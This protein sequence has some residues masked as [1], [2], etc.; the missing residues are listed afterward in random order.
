MQESFHRCDIGIGNILLHEEGEPVESVFT[1]LET[2]LEIFK[3]IGPDAAGTHDRLEVKLAALL[4]KAKIDTRCNG[5]I[6]DGD[7]AINL[8]EYFS[9]THEGSR[10][11]WLLNLVLMHDTD[12]FAGNCRIHVPR[13]VRLYRAGKAISAIPCR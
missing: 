1:N 10:S 3:R 11:V 9:I 12:I 13:H 7:A 8:K 2:A 4:K 6:I 5:F